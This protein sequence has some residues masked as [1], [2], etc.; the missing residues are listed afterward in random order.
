MIARGVRRFEERTG[1]TATF[2]DIDHVIPRETRAYVPMFIATAL[3][4]S[5]PD[6]YG[7]PA[8]EPGPSYVFDQIP[9]AGGT[10]L[11]DVYYAVGSWL[12]VVGCQNRTNHENT[13]RNNKISR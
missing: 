10:R 3:I 13:I 2:W 4:L 6:A 8:H 5:N 7:F 9:V 1:Q 11:R 12:V